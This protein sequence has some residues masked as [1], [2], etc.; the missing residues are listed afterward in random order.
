MAGICFSDPSGAGN[1]LEVQVTRN[2]LT[3]TQD[4]L[5]PR[6]EWSNR[7][8]CSTR[9]CDGRISIN[10]KTRWPILKTNLD[11]MI[12]VLSFPRRFGTSTDH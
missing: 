1:A 12:S 9:F 7:L 11:W 2:R 5:H 8:D 6:H 4:V 3:C 10:L